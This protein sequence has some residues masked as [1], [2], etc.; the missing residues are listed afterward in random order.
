[1]R[2]SFRKKMINLKPTFHYNLNP[3][4]SYLKLFQ[5]ANQ[6][7][8]M[9]MKEQQKGKSLGKKFLNKEKRHYSK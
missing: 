9:V 5:L 6:N 2:L 3:I 1:M 7:L 4:D 8:I